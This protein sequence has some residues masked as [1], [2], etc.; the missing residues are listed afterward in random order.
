MKFKQLGNSEIKT[1]LIA[2]G[3]MT[4][5]EQNSE[6][7]A[8]QQ[9]DM[10]CDFGINFFD[11]AELYAIPPKAETHGLTEQYIGNWFKSR[12]RR[13]QIILA[14][15]VAG[16]GAGWV[17]HIRGGPRLNREHMTRALEASLKRLQT[18]YIDLYQIHWPE[19]S[20]NFFGK[21]GYHHD[22]DEDVIAIE[23]TLEVLNDFVKSGKVRQI[24]VSN[25]TPWGVMQYLRYADKY[26][27]PRIVSI[28]NPYNLLN[29]SFE[30]GLAEMA[31]REDVGLLAYS[32]LGFGVLSAKYLQPEP[33]PNARLTLFPDYTR[34]SNDNGVAAT[35]AYAELAR[36]HGISPT[37]LAL[38]FVNQQ[39]FTSANII[40]A[41]TLG[42]LKENI[43][44]IELV[45]SEQILTQIDAIHNRYTIPC[46]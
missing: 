35:R 43:E 8:Y 44:S 7:E 42:Q 20:T 19:R 45:L 4:F 14:S 3:T 6:P 32:P 18:D 24:G 11:T 39:R 33:P 25:E 34:Y 27:W 41:T 37:Q 15:K 22:D 2:L 9:M 23:Q 13:D 26:N 46:P 36:E 12:G 21:L 29:R 31:I 5:G 17:D 40:G 10:A 30:V 16:P 38:A 1:S 28:Q